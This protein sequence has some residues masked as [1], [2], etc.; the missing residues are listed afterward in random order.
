[1]DG[2][3]TT[4]CKF[5]TFAYNAEQGKKVEEPQVPFLLL[6]IG[7]CSPRMME[8]KKEFYL[9]LGNPFGGVI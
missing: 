4:Y 6:L 9:R 2:D 1:M 7:I 5:A 8:D 3:E